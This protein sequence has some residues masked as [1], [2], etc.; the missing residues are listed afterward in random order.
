MSHKLIDDG[1]KIFTKALVKFEKAYNQAEEKYD[2]VLERR[3]YLED[4][5]KEEQAVMDRASKYI[6]KINNFLGE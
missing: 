3:K 1:L 4:Q 6:T 5:Q 2:L